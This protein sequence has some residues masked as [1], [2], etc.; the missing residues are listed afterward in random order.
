MRMHRDQGMTLIEL[1][2]AIGLFAVIAVMSVQALS[3][4][5]HSRDRIAEMQAQSAAILQ[6]LALLR[7]DLSAVVPVPFY[8][9]EGAPRSSVML[10]AR[11]QVLELSVAGQYALS[12][13]E[14][15]RG[16]RVH[17]VEWRWNSDTSTLSRRMWTAMT[18]LNTDALAADVTVMTG[19]TGLA[20]RSLWPR[21]GGWQ[22]GLNPQIGGGAALDGDAR[23]LGFSQVLPDAIE[24]TLSTAA[25][26]DIRLL[27]VLQ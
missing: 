15:L 22:P 21:G 25:H 20:V 19:V 5:L 10:S 8:P 3:G 18:P 24:I 14:A 11:G 9:P 6:P 7:N 12:A 17:R 27:E 26:G 1:V 4:V 16:D 23:R 2:A 13:G